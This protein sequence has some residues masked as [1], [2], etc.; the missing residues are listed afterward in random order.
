MLSSQ[1]ELVDP[2]WELVQM[3]EAGAQQAPRQRCTGEGKGETNPELV[4][5]GAMSLNDY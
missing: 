1:D 2:V 5:S 4:Y 3:L